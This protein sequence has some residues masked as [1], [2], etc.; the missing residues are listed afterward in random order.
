M[1]SGY[2]RRA[3][4]LQLADPLELMSGGFRH[5]KIREYFPK[6]PD[7]PAPAD[8]DHLR[9]RLRLPGQLLTG[10]IHEGAVWVAVVEHQ[11]TDTLRMACRVGDGDHATLAQTDQREAAKLERIDN[12]LKVRHH[13]IEG[14]IGHVAIGKTRASRV[15]TDQH[16]PFDQGLGPM[17][18]D[19]IVPIELE[20]REPVVN[21][22]Q[23][24]TLTRRRKSDPYVVA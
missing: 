1:A 19:R 10:V 21:A 6:S 18:P 23:R 8:F 2:R 24:R 13:G 20:V 14:K 11:A 5:Q 22:H 7:L 15:V 12:R 17:A 3:A 9:E 4:P 16:S